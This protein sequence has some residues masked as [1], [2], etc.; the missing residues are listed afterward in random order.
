MYGHVVHDFIIRRLTAST[1]LVALAAEALGCGAAFSQ[2]IRVSGPFT[3]EHA[4][5]FENGVDTISDPTI[6][7]G[8]W[9]RSWEEDLDR[10][11]SLADAIALV[12]ITTVRQD[13]DLDRRETYRLVARVDERR[14][15]PVPDE[16]TLVVRQ[17]EPGFDTVRG[18][19]RRLLNQRFV[20]FLK[21][22]EDQ[23]RVVA[24]WHLSPGAEGV[25]R[26][27]NRLLERRLPP[28]ERR[29]VIVVDDGSPEREQ[30]EE[31][32]EDP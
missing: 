29:R 5:A 8:A 30:G 22:V 19:E 28:A 12:T 2:D 25:V 16:V 6:L 24:R 10:R 23:G 7:Q 4:I 3:E 20:A 32:G 11:V 27:V 13:L 15:G 26:R 9:L 21:W 17:G 18:H 1:V 31:P 14:H